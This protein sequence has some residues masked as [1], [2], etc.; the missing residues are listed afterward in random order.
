MVFLSIVIYTLCVIKYVSF[1]HVYVYVLSYDM[2]GYLYIYLFIFCEDL[3]VYSFQM[4]HT[5][6]TV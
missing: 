1:L 4:C 6:D 3:C 5:V 2:Q